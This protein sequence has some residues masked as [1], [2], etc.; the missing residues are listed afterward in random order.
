MADVFLSDSCPERGIFQT[1]GI[2]FSSDFTLQLDLNC[3]FFHL[4]ELLL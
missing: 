4:S 2:K 1:F 3:P